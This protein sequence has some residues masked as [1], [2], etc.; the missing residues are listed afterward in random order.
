[1]KMSLILMLG[2]RIGHQTSSDTG[3][4]VRHKASSSKSADTPNQSPAA[5]AFGGRAKFVRT[6]F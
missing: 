2:I 6:I 5:T 1:L 3:Q 4:R